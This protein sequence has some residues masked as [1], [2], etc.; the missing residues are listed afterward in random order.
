MNLTLGLMLKPHLKLILSLIR[1]YVAE[2]K[3]YEL[4]K[5]S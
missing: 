2:N 4:I 3:L 1:A 5:V